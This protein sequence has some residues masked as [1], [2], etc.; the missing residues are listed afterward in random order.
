MFRPV[1]KVL[2]LNFLCTLQVV[3]PPHSCFASVLIHQQTVTRR[4]SFVF[5]DRVTSVPGA[6]D[7]PEM[8]QWSAPESQ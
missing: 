4:R 3:F 2:L 6:R 1:G 8:S 7:K 5:P